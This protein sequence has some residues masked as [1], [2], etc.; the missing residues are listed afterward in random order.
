MKGKVVSVSEINTSSA[1]WTTCKAEIE[2]NG[3]V[4]KGKVFLGKNQTGAWFK[5]GDEIEYDEKEGQYGLEFV[6]K[7]PSA[8]GGKPQMGTNFKE[9]RE[10]WVMKNK[11]IIAQSSMSSAVEYMRHLPQEKVNGKMLTDIAEVIYNFVL[12]KSELK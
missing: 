1:G 8:G 3:V 4:K 7:K 6:C 10:D 5:V 2:N 12:S 9:S 11:S